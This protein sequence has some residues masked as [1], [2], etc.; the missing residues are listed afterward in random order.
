MACSLQERNG[1]SALELFREMIVVVPMDIPGK[2]GEDLLKLM[3]SGSSHPAAK[4]QGKEVNH[5]WGGK[6]FWDKR[7]GKQ[8]SLWLLFFCFKCRMK[9]VSCRKEW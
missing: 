8:Y 6:M 2:H 9:K 7:Q 4:G 1:I 3:S 5:L